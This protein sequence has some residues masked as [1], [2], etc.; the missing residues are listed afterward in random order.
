MSLHF[1]KRL[2]SRQAEL[3]SCLCVGLDPDIRKTPMRFKEVQGRV[4]PEAVAEWMIEIVEATAPFA[5]MFKLQRAYWENLPFGSGEAA[6]RK[7][8]EYIRANYPQIPICIDAKR[9]DIGRTM[10]QYR[11]ACFL[12]DQADA[13]N[14]SGY[15]GSS[16]FLGL[17]D[18]DYPH[19]S[20]VNLIYTSNPEARQVQDAAMADGRPLWMHMAE[21]TLEWADSVTMKNTGFV[22][23]AAYTPEGSQSVHSRHLSECRKIDQGTAWYLIPG[24]GAQG[25]ALE[26]T[27][28]ASW[29]DYGSI[30]INSSSGICM[31]SVDSDYAVAAAAAAADVHR[32]MEACIKSL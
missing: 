4:Y 23:A 27:I 26:E 32:K 13:V 24:Y 3:G 2:A 10:E 29:V 25:G 20:I 8:V 30:A 15:M 18:E 17:F 12:K 31:A 28:M 6:M 14:C 7:V 1:R 21:W 11:D 9:Q 5:S 19:R 16:P 22:M